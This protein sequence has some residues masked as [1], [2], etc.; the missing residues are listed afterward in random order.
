[1][2]KYQFAVQVHTQYLPAQSA[3]EEGV[4]RFAYTITIT[5]TGDIA[6][7]LIARE[8]HIHDAHGV[9][10]QVRGLGVVGRQPLLQPG[11]VHRYTS[12]CEL[13]TSHGTM[14][15][16]YLCIAEDAELF[17]TA[18]ALFTLDASDAGDD[19]LPTPPASRTLH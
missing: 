14:H 5:N 3:P 8:W 15:G 12:G 7:Q 10:Q 1:M 16:S 4:Y 11:E 13:S 19:T 2:P 18:I 9:E 17:H 6:A